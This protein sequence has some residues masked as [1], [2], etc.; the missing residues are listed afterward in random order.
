MKQLIVLLTL[1]ILTSCMDH[2]VLNGGIVHTVNKQYDGT[3]FCD[4]KV[5][6]YKQ[7]NNTTYYEIF[8]CPPETQP[9]DTLYFVYK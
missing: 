7:Q 4:V 9:G 3:C 6:R 2:E 5:T 8:T 1:V